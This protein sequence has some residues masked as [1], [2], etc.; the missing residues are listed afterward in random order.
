[1]VFYD[2]FGAKELTGNILDRPKKFKNKNF[3]G[4]KEWILI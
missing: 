2:I 1:M 3:E 4:L